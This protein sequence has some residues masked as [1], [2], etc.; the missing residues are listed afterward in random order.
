MDLE[1]KPEIEQPVKRGKGRPKKGEIVVKKPKKPI[2]RPRVEKKP[3]EPKE[4]KKIGRPKKYEEGCYRAKYK[5][6]IIDYNRYLEL[7]EK[8]KKLNEFESVN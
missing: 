8:E 5:R 4:P 3:K 6:I 2:G 1:I 7:I